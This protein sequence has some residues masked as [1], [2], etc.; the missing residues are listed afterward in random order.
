MSRKYPIGIQSFEKLRSAGYVYVDKTRYVW[1]L[2]QEGEYYFMSRPRRFGK[3]LLISTLEAFF[4]GRRDLFAGLY[5]DGVDYD[6]TEYPV[7]HIDLNSQNYNSDDGSLDRMLDSALAEWEQDFGLTPKYP[8]ASLRFA[9]VIK[10]I[11]QVTGRR[12]VVLIDEYDKPLLDNIFN[13]R[14]TEDFRNT[15]KA[16]YG[17][18]KSC[19]P[20]IRFAF[21]TGV[22]RFGK[23]SVFSDLNNLRDITLQPTYN[24]LCGVSE[25]E[26]AGVFGEDIRN[27]ADSIGDDY[28]DTL[29]RL[30]RCYD[31]YRFTRKATEGIYNPYSLLNVLQNRMFDDYW[32]NTGTPA[33]LVELIKRTNMPLY[34][35]DN[36][37][38]TSGDL[39]GLEPAFRDPV[40]ILFQSGYLTVKGFDERRARYRLGF[41][42]EEVERGL[43]ESLLPVYLGKDV[44]KNE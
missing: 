5:I 4:R 40:P 23:V 9:S 21:L 7:L 33:M 35:F 42:N 43:L 2:V 13:T 10:T 41:P 1:Q 39:T 6:W 36:I 22:T 44:P 27:L 14:R 11:Y 12:V 32:F 8:D 16:F 25:S 29:V 17:V 31:G 26:L 15:L 38:R 30:K 18:L 24:A 28:G 34:D 19:D 20:Y 3:S 37:E